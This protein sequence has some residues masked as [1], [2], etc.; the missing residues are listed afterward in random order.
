MQTPWTSLSG[1]AGV[2]E[3]AAR[4]DHVDLG[5]NSRDVGAKAILY[6]DGDVTIQ[7]EHDDAVVLEPEQVRALCA[8]L[9][10]QPVLDT[11]LQEVDRGR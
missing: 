2:G 5:V 8:F 6:S 3:A 9:L 10:T 7:T 1:V 11:V 4:V